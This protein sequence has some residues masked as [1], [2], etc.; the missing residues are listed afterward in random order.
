VL[1]TRSYPLEDLKDAER[2]F[3]VHA[4]R[5][6]VR[7]CDRYLAAVARDVYDRNRARR[8]AERAQRRAEG[9]QRRS[10][11]STG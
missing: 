1:D 10:R 5:C 3:R 9:E 7:V 2:R 6:E 11:C 8:V 4:C